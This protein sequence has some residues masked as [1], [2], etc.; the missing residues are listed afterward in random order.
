VAIEHHATLDIAKELAMVEN[1]EKER[2][3]LSLITSASFFS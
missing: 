3:M 1:N 2:A